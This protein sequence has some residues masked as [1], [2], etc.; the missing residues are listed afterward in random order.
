MD[1][2]DAVIDLLT[3]NS[4]EGEDPGDGS[5]SEG[6]SATIDS[7]VSPDEFREDSPGEIEATFRKLAHHRRL[8]CIRPETRLISKQSWREFD[9]HVRNDESKREQWGIGQTLT[10]PT[11]NALVCKRDDEIATARVFENTYDEST[12]TTTGETTDRTV[13]GGIDTG[14]NVTAGGT[15]SSQESESNTL[16][17][18]ATE[19]KRIFE[20]GTDLADCKLN[21]RAFDKIGNFYFSYGTSNRDRLRSE[22]ERVKTELGI[23]S[24]GPMDEGEDTRPRT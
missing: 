7:A 14:V 10:D 16:R 5:G 3:T 21:R 8:E 4:T 1:A 11:K 22:V 2:I 20:C 13:E 15:T 23:E 18:G 9:T 6:E 12:T 17:T 24:E 19:R